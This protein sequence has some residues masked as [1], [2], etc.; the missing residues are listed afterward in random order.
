MN[1]NNINIYP[2]YKGSFQR[3]LKFFGII[4]SIPLANVIRTDKQI[5]VRKVK[6]QS[7]KREPPEISFV[8]K[9]IRMIIQTIYRIISFEF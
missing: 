9:F 3:I 5:Y 1:F 4:D 2:A 8:L 7:E 6:I